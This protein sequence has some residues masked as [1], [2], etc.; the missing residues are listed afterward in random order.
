MFAFLPLSP[1]SLLFLLK[2][3]ND[4]LNQKRNFGK[5]PSLDA[6]SLRQLTQ[7]QR[8]R[9]QSREQQN[10]GL[11][12][13]LQ[14]ALNKQPPEENSASMMHAG[15]DSGRDLGTLRDFLGKIVACLRRL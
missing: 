9:G 10:T 12:Q 11:R 7:A 15:Q 1:F 4:S 6:C 8:A 3:E 2:L 14:T 13:H 5:H